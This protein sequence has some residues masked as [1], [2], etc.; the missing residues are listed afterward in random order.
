M[1]QKFSG[2]PR[3]FPDTGCVALI[4]KYFFKLI[5]NFIQNITEGKFPA[6]GPDKQGFT[7]LMQEPVSDMSVS[8]EEQHQGCGVR[9]GQRPKADAAFP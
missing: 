5:N 9:T 1:L 3:Y 7:V 6:K 4:F 2:K 8:M